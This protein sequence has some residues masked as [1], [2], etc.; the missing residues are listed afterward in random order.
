[1]S[2]RGDIVRSILDKAVKYDMPPSDTAS[3]INDIF[4]N[5]NW[6]PDNR[7]TIDDVLESAK[8]SATDK[9]SLCDKDAYNKW[10]NKY[11]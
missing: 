11:Q 7:Y 6:D 5:L 3:L 8:F 2:M 9:Y 10:I 1:M 4:D